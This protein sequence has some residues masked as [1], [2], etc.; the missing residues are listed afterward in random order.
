MP[1]TPKDVVF[2]ET[3]HRYFLEGKELTSVTSA[4]EACGI[5]DFSRVPLEDLERAMRIGDYVHLMAKLYAGGEL[6]EASIDPDLMGY[7]QAI[8]SFFDSEVKEVIATE[9]II[10]NNSLSYAG[11]VDI[12][13]RNKSGLAC[14]DDYKTS[15]TAHPA[16]KLQTAAYKRAYQR[17]YGT[18]IDRR[19]GVLLG[20]TGGYRREPYTDPSDFG[21][22]VNALATARWKRSNKLL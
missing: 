2:F 9:C 15:R 14:L 1:L 17:N 18:K 4:L 7:Y 10:F 13:Y 3:T 19:G 20:P 12:V 5:T 21:H 16:A 6:D 11:T 8:K 22:F